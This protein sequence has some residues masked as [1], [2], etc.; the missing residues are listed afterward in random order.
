MNE[1]LLESLLDILLHSLGFV[2]Q[3]RVD[4]ALRRRRACK[5]VDGTGSG[6]MRETCGVGLG[7]NLPKI[8]VYLRDVGLKGNHRTLNQHRITGKG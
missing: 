2:H 7:K 1:T 4:V 3:Q 5:Q 8:V 6:A